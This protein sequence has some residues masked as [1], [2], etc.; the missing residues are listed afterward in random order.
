M[1]LPADKLEAVPRQT[2][3]GEAE[4]VI[5]G[6]VLTFMVIDALAVQYILRLVA[7]TV[8]VVVASGVT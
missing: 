2:F 4:A 3:V 5:T 7:V 6:F 1:L 8:Q